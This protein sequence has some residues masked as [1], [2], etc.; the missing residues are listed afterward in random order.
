MR[1][2]LLALVL[3]AALAPSVRAEDRALLIGIDAYAE[4]AL[5]KGLGKSAAADLQKMRKTL[6]DTYGYGEAQLRILKDK[7][8]TKSAILGS[9]K[10]W[11][12]GAGKGERAFLY[13]AGHG[14][15][16]TDKS[17]D[18]KD[19]LDEAIVPFDAKL[20][21]GTDPDNL[22]SDDAFTDALAALDGRQVV[23]V[24]DASFSGRVTRGKTSAVGA[25]RT[26]ELGGA[27]RSIVVEPRVVAQKAEEGFVEKPLK[28]GSLAVWSAASASQAALIE[29][30][31][32]EAGGLFTR[33]F[34][35]AVGEGKA[36]RNGNGAISNAEVLGY[37][38]DGSKAFCEANKTRC[39]MGLAPRLD[40]PE[41]LGLDAIGKSETAG[42]GTAKPERV[43]TKSEDKKSGAGK[44][45]DKLTLDR[46]TDFLA[47]GNPDKVRLAQHPSSP[48]HVGQKDVRFEVLSPH[49]GFL[50]LLDLSDE[51]ELI[52]LYPNQFSR[53]HE[54]QAAG[55]VRAGSSLT[56]P[57]AYYGL[58][59][60][61]TKPNSGHVIAIVT[62]D[63]VE[64]GDEV[65]TRRIE[66]IPRQEA[67]QT[68]LPG[69]AKSLNK[70]LN[71][72]EADKNT[73]FAHW[74]VAT[75]RYEILP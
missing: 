53:K 27:T 33:L 49:E 58:K 54:S 30:E 14:H 8:A 17:G 64:F 42:S 70:P 75:L 25:A 2:V 35:E 22:I 36:D 61:A 55:M 67:V 60:N 72:A 62:R 7:D 46:V 37:I 34:V 23:V 69:L 48:V 16:L 20:R 74:S 51:G 63:K 39:E 18:E 13:F 11:L 40:P 4:P 15:F 50:I 71:S 24:L 10:D 1:H 21:N 12:G 59:F 28:S 43:S 26:P 44:P 66:V 32:G 31:G 65:K 41:A 5:A 19:G 47:K 45:G 68:F 38:A 3:A 6:L 52:Q 56:V 57:D 9:I 73:G 29:E